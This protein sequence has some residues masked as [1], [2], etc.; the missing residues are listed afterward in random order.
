VSLDEMDSG[1]FRTFARAA[2]DEFGT[3]KVDN[4]D[5]DTFA[6]NI[7]SASSPWHFASREACSRPAP[8]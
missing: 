5:W 8:A 6:A 3:R 4:G 7:D 2:L 1:A